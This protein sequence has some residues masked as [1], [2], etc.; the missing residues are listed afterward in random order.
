MNLFV[1]YVQPLTDWLQQNP[2][3]SLFITFLISLTE[4]L[5]IIGSIVPGS[6]TMTAIGILAG[7]GIMRVDLT[8][9]AAILGAVAGDSLSYA[10]GYYYSEQ[11]IDMWP[12]K[13]YPKWLQYGKDFFKAHGGKSVLVG[14]FVGPLRSIIPVIAGI[15][16]MKQ[17]HFLVANVLSAIGWS[18]LY[19]MPGVVL[20]AASHELSTENAT[21]LFLLILI[22]LAGIWLISLI[23]KWLIKQLNSF[24]KLSLHN[25]WLKFKNNSLLASVYQALTPKN[26]KDH[27]PTASLVL[28]AF[29]C[30]ISFTIL[31]GLTIKTSWLSYINLPIYL[32]F[33]SFN[34]TTLKVFFI[35]CTQLTSTITIVS[36]FI[37][38][39][40]WFIYQKKIST[41]I[42]LLS[43]ITFNCLLILLLKFFVYVPRPTGILVVMPDSS[44]PAINI[45]IATAL[46][47]FILFYI[48]S[49]YDLFTNVL[50]S[51][52]YA[53]LGLSG[54]GAIYLGDYWF[55]DIIASY[56]AGAAICLVHC[57]VYRKANFNLKKASFSVLVFSPFLISILLFSFLSTSYHFKTLSYNHTSYHQQYT[58]S[59]KAWW[60]QKKP[61]LPIYQLSRI[62]KRISLLN[63]QYAGDLYLFQHSLE[64]HGWESHLDSFFSNLLMHMNKEPNRV[65]LP[66]LTQL[67]ENKPPVL[68]MTYTEKKSDLIL[69]LRIWES[70]YTLLNS[71]K[72][73][74]I[75]SIHSSKSV[76]KQKNMSSFKELIDPLHYIVKTEETFAVKQILL[77]KETVKTTRYPVQPRI[78]LI[79]QKNLSSN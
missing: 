73:L 11:L 42:Y 47:G 74:W 79:K 15:L 30:I 23:F 8:L 49:T 46:Y 76:S 33:Q 18:L 10:L 52:M 26:E 35:F 67:Y 62:G 13:K 43:L 66:L 16:H 27:Y 59:E 19:V 36:F 69:E 68:I 21:H 58:L 4:S 56:F 20:G 1:D 50:K 53:L 72:P 12:F 65:K 71:N 32:F 51:I 7:S 24:L 44:F 6:V 31:L 2:H 25:L 57:L 60:Q 70:N 37:I 45:E 28:I 63:L 55:T 41:L 9:L 29:F 78:I 14:R 40:C 75:G 34:T 22:L 48:K 54:L 3:W 77:P 17:W 39:T 38:S 61:I 5:A 64:D